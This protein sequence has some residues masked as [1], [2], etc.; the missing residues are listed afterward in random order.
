M[1]KRPLFDLSGL[2]RPVRPIETEPV[3]NFADLFSTVVVE[4]PEAFPWLA[5]DTQAGANA[6]GRYNGEEG[7]PAGDADFGDDA[8]DDFNG[9]GLPAHLDVDPNELFLRAD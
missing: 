7:L 8:D 1:G 5:T 2:S 4:N 3:H 9:S 6:A